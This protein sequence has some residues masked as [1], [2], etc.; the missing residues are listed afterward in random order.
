MTKLYTKNKR[1]TGK[2]L[3]KNERIVQQHIMMRDRKKVQGG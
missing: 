1:R 2:N 3:Q